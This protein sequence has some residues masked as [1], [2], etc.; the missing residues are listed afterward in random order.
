MSGKWESGFS[1]ERANAKERSEISS[2]AGIND[3]GF[4]VDGDRFTD[5]YT[6]ASVFD[7][8]EDEMNSG[9]PS[10]L[11]SEVTLPLKGHKMSGKWES[12]FRLERAN[13]KERSEISSGVGINDRGFFVDGDRFTDEYTAAS[14]F[15]FPEDEMNSPYSSSIS[16]GPEDAVEVI[17]F[18]QPGQSTASKHSGRNMENSDEDSEWME[19]YGSVD[20]TIAASDRSCN[21]CGAKFHCKDASL[22]GFLPVEIFSKLESTKASGWSNMEVSIRQSQHQIGVAMDVVRNSTARLDASLPG[23]LPVEIFSKLESTKGAEE[24]LCRRCYLLEKHNF[25]L[26]VNVCEVDYRSVMC[27]LKLKQE[28]LIILVVDM[29]DL[30]ASIYAHLPEIIGDRKPMVVVGNKVDLLPPDQRSGYLK[31]FRETLFKAVED[32]GFTRRFNVLHVA[33]ISAKTGFGVEELITN[34]HLKWSTRGTAI[35][36]DIYLVGCT[37]AGKSTLFNTLLQSDLCKVRAVDLVQ[38]ATTSIWPGTTISLLKFPVMNPTPHK[39]E[40]RRRR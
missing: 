40:L 33:L 36:N 12:G 3:R 39:L 9:F 25:L 10:Q 35:R 18:Q 34:I 4:F 24:R 27:H 29:S 17:E 20:P 8:P 38:R 26:N 22:P 2:G 31:H 23:F 30:P 6:A 14:V 15:D 11:C 37:N 16:Y 7:F 28:A 19:Q 32:V 1:S 5:E 21:G 13:A